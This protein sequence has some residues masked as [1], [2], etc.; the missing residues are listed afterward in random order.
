[1]LNITDLKQV[2]REEEQEREK[3]QQELA[4]LKAE[5]TKAQQELARER[6]EL[7]KQKTEYQKRTQQQ[8]I[9]LLKAKE[10]RQQELHKQRI[11]Q[12]LKQQKADNITYILSIGITFLS[13]L[14][15]FI[16][17]MAILLKG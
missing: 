7:N 12:A 8:K 3:A 13:I 1:M 2:F 6:H 15:S 16:L 10:H 14:T 17:F 5:T 4:R 11:K 9:A